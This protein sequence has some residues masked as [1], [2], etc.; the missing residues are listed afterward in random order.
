MENVNED[1]L[2]MTMEGCCTICK[3]VPTSF[4]QKW[5]SDQIAQVVNNAS[6]SPFMIIARLSTLIHQVPSIV[7]E[8]DWERVLFSLQNL[9]PC[10]QDDEYAMVPY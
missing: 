8:A 6:L 10:I 9:L 3:V 7:T 2:V 5:V 1:S 4:Q